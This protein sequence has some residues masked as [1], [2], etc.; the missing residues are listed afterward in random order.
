MSAVL[1]A[2]HTGSRDETAV[3]EQCRWGGTC[4]PL[5]D[6][7]CLQL[8]RPGLEADYGWDVFGFMAVAKQQYRKARANGCRRLPDVL[9][10]AQELAELVDFEALS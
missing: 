7:H 4:I 5:A 9:K 10:Q 2:P 8:N 6:L 1:E 3:C